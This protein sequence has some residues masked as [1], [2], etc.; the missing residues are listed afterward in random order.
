MRIL[1]LIARIIESDNYSDMF[2]HLEQ[3]GVVVEL[4]DFSIITQLI[5]P[6]C[7]FACCD[8]IEKSAW[9]VAKLFFANKPA[10]IS[11]IVLENDKGE[12]VAN[13][14]GSFILNELDKVDLDFIYIKL[15]EHIIKDV[16]LALTTL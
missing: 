14:V 5:L 4:N 13:D 8:F 3:E 7:D 1:E 2:I 15:C 16:N 9:V 11:Q 6:L 10:R 12:C